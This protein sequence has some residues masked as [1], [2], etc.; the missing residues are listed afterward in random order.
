MHWSI[1]SES[2][3]LQEMD[4]VLFIG[5]FLRISGRKVTSV[6]VF[7]LRLARKWKMSENTFSGVGGICKLKSFSKC[8]GKKLIRNPARKTES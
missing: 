1:S 6:R 8:A 4:F 3:P 7:V 5:D 2:D